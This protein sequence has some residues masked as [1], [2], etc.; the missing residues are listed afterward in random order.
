MEATGWVLALLAAVVLVMISGLHVYWALGGV[1]PG[2]DGPSLAQRVFGGPPGTPLPAVGACLAV[3]ALL[4]LAAW[5]VIGAAWPWWMLPAAGLWR[6]GAWGVAGVLALRGGLGFFDTRLRPAIVGSPFVR[7]NRLV[8]SPL[9]LG[10]GLCIGAA[11]LI[12]P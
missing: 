11:L 8:Y 7:L 3:A 12:Q 1:W 5:T 10:L 2:H 6:L 9:C 4:L